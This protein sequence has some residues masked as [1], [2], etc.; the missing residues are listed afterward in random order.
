MST[1]VSVP[2]DLSA[3]SRKFGRLS[4]RAHPGK[5]LEDNPDLPRRLIKEIMIGLGEL[6]R[7]EKREYQLE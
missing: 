7:G 3:T 6:D 2:E 4:Q 1:R 5:C